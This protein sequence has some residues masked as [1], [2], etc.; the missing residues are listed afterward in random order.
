[1]A[2]DLRRAGR[3]LLDEVAEIDGRFGTRE[4]GQG[5]DDEVRDAERLGD[6]ADGPAFHLDRL[7]MELLE[8]PNARRLAVQELIAGEDGAEAD[9]RGARHTTCGRRRERLEAEADEPLADP[10]EEMLGRTIAELIRGVEEGHVPGLVG[11]DPLALQDPGIVL[12]RALADDDIADV[13]GR[14]EPAGHPGEDEA[15]TAEAVG[16]Q[17]GGQCRV[18][19]ADPA[20][21]EHQ[22]MPVERTGDEGD[23]AVPAR[24]GRRHGIGEM[25]E[26]LRDGA[27]DADGH[28]RTPAIVCPKNGVNRRGAIVQRAITGLD[29]L[30]IGVA[31]LEAARR[32]WARLGFNATPRGRHVGWATANYCIMFEHDYLELLGIVDPD[33]FSNGLDRLLAERGEGLLGVA[34]HSSD[35]A[36][37]A[38]AWQAAGLASAKAGSLL[39]LLESETPA[40]ELRFANVMLD[41]VDRSGLNLFGCT[42]LTPEP[43]RR[44]AWLRHPNGALRIAGLTV[45]VDDVEPLAALAEQIVGSAA[46]TRTDQV[47]AIQTGTAPIMLATPDDAAL[48]HPGFTLPE[49]A[50]EPL[51]AV[52]EIAVA[53]PAATA[54]FLAQQEV[55]HDWQSGVAVLVD[56]EHAN[57]VRLAFV[58]G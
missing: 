33:G 11:V 1:M 18:D 19:L 56:P 58:A 31:D 49:A 12:Q 38:A 4:V 29:H 44:P 57:G 53:D 3:D 24:F 48:L 8:E 52:L 7:A 21:G 10:G 5:A 2:H 30:I 9:D 26:L 54:R 14:V 43:M 45:I 41:P 32:Q 28:G 6:L 36:A 50:P 17:G 35:A 47:R 20:P 42:H 16:E 40:V 15:A 46:V 25:A 13:K 37:T 27:D 22:A 51:L 55:P 23:A 39:R 34:L